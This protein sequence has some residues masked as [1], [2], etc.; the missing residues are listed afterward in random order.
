MK[1]EFSSNLSLNEEDAH[2]YQFV[3][4]T[5]LYG[6]LFGVYARVHS[7]VSDHEAKLTKIDFIGINYKGDNTISLLSH[8][9]KPTY[10][11]NQET[12]VRVLQIKLEV[13]AGRNAPQHIDPVTLDLA[14]T[15][16]E[17][18][19]VLRRGDYLKIQRMLIPMVTDD[20]LPLV[21]RAFYNGHFD[22][23]FYVRDGLFV[24]YK[25]QNPDDIDYDRSD[26]IFDN[27]RENPA[28][29][30]QDSGNLL[31]SIRCTPGY[32]KIYF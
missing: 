17:D 15:F 7:E 29:D 11:K 13:Q 8:F 10:A 20:S 25:D 22:S 9:D 31:G 24:K 1:L 27:V 14:G 3:Y 18:E 23:E 19:F 26:L 2:R 16:H 4:A 6:T 28:I 30:E 32:N 12:G 21:E 5:Q